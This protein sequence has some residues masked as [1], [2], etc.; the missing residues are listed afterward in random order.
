M[1]SIQSLGI[2]SG[3]LTTELVDDIIAAEREATDLRI[4]AERA[5]LDAKISAFG[6]VKS[7]LDGLRTA[8]SDTVDSTTHTV[9]VNVTNVNGPVNPT[10]APSDI[11]PTPPIGDTITFNANGS[12]I[13]FEL[14]VDGA[15]AAAG[16][17]P[18]LLLP[19]QDPDPVAA[20]R[21][22]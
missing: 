10:L 19:F 16:N 12:S 3:L 8:A 20:R 13:T 2:G 5:A 15:T 9:T 11:V 22:C 1:P 4:D 17:T 18:I 6:S 7:S 14:V 21:P